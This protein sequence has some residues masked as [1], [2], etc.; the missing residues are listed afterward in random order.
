MVYPISIAG[1]LHAH[2][3]GRVEPIALDA[4][5]GHALHAD[6]FVSSP[7]VFAGQLSQIGLTAAAP[8]VPMG[9]SEHAPESEPLVRPEPQDTQSA[10]A[11]LPLVAAAVPAACTAQGR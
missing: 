10:R 1:S 3:E 5:G 6:I 2:A 7:K 4:P 11:T 8:K 9:Q